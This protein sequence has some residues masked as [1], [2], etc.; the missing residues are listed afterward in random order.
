MTWIPC[1]HPWYWLYHQN[2][3]LRS[4]EYNNKFEK[5]EERSTLR[6]RLSPSSSTTRSDCLASRSA[7]KCYI[8]G[9]ISTTI[10]FH[11]HGSIAIHSP[12]Q[13]FF[14]EFDPLHVFG[15]QLLQLGSK[16]VCLV[17]L[18]PDAIQP[19]GTTTSAELL[20]HEWISLKP[21]SRQPH[22]SVFEVGRCR[23][24][25]HHPHRQTVSLV[26]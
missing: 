2:M 14:L 25:G 3:R 13:T 1:G 20:P 21:G 10:S 16:H 6:W 7:T 22:R 5:K 24:C 19:S 4:S 12:K 17:P 15:M 9:C 23:I 11:E 26:S 8:V 18:T